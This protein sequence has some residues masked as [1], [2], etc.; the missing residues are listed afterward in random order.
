[1]QVVF[2]GHVT[3]ISD[4]PN[5]VLR[6]QLPKPSTQAMVLILMDN[7]DGRR[8]QMLRPFENTGVHVMF[9]V[10][11]VVATEGKSWKTAM[12]FVDQ[13]DNRHT[14]KKCVFRA[15]PGPPK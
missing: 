15:L 14:V 1:M 3:N 6:A 12:I 5:K 7:H 8:P 13:Y 2:E 11:P 10:L 9:S 4:K